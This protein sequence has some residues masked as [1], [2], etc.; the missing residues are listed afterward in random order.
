MFNIGEREA[1]RTFTSKS[2]WI[3]SLCHLKTVLF[4]NFSHSSSHPH[5][6]SQLLQP[7]YLTHS[8]PQAPEHLPLQNE[9]NVSSFYHQIKYPRPCH[10]PC[11]RLHGPTNHP[12][13]HSRLLQQLY[14]PLLRHG[15][16]QQG[17]HGGTMPGI[18]S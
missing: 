16:W 13:G 3:I 4:S 6:S 17:D 14:R 11:P 9:Q 1:M 10:Y 5:P 7:S 12:P 2:R 18:I 15:E 8:P